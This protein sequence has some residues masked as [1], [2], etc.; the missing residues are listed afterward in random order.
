VTP[1]LSHN[2]AN[3]ETELRLGP[4]GRRVFTVAGW[5]DVLRKAGIFAGNWW[6]ANYGPM[7][8]N[9]HYAINM[10]GY[11]EGLY[12]FKAYKIH[13]G[14]ESPFVGPTRQL[15]SNFNARS[16]TEATASKGRARFWIV[17]PFG[18]PVNEALSK[19]FRHIPSRESA[20][21]AREYRRA[22]IVGLQTGRAAHAAK[23]QARAAARAA[24][25]QAKADD[26]ATLRGMRRQWKSDDRAKIRADR[27]SVRSAARQL[28]RQRTRRAKIRLGK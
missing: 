14:Y 16:R 21:V 11:P 26:R 27:A 12:P 17:C 18:H 23:R 10:L 5:N 15:I 3:R 24:K 9:G 25:R 28:R 13:R 1:A 22:V 4:K 8:F 7:R 20:A 2:S 19:A 6:I